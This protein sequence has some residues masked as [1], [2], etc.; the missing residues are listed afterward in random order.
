M[1]KKKPAPK[2]L[3]IKKYFK[4]TYQNGQEK[5]FY[6]QGVLDNGHLMIEDAQTRN[7]TFPDEATLR[8]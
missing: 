1:G 6:V 4:V 5:R 7:I 8:L 2:Q 3:A